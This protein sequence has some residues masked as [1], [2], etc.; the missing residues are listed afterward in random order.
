MNKLTDA[1]GC[2]EIALDIK[3]QTST[4]IATNLQLAVILH[5]F[6]GCLF[7]MNEL[8]NWCDGVVIRVLTLHSINLGFWGFISLIKPYQKNFKNGIYSFPAQC[9]A[10]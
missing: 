10:Q 4:N 8:T 6:G 1:K 2:L 9:S 7:E 3:Q 5:D